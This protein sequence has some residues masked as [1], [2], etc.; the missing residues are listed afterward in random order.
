MCCVCM[1]YASKLQTNILHKIFIYL[2]IVVALK[3]GIYNY[4]Y[5]DL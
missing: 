2:L 1:Q 5:S 3:I 4:N